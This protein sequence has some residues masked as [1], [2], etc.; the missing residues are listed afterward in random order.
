MFVD[1]LKLYGNSIDNIKDLLKI[2]VE[3]SKN[4]GM[5]FDEDKCSYIYVENGKRRTLG[6]NI[7]MNRMKTS[8]LD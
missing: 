1:D 2:V 6:N 8:E 4:I 5:N 3:F 7:D